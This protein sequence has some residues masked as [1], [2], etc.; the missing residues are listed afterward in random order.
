[1]SFLPPGSI[2]ILNYGYLVV[3]AVGG[4][5]FFRSVIVALIPRLTDAHDSRRAGRGA[6]F[7]RL[8]MR[9]M[10]AISLPLTAFM[11]VLATS[12]RLA[13]FRTRPASRWPT[14]ELLGTV[15]V[16]YAISLVGSAVQRALLAPFFARLDTRTPLR[17]TFYGV[18]ANLVLAAGLHARR[19]ACTTSMA[20]IGVALAYSLAQYVNVGHALVPPVPASTATPAADWSA[21]RSSSLSRRSLTAAV[22]DRGVARPRSL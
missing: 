20:I 18:V 17:N 14:A 4:T 2:S 15:L 13:V 9:I 12:G 21:S 16:V 7:H 19:S 5:V 8:G 6:P 10:L 22:D 1:M 3:S 11:A